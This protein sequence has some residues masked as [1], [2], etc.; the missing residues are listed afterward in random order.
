MQPG[1]NVFGFGALHIGQGP[2]ALGLLIHLVLDSFHYDRV[3]TAR[4]GV[5]K[6][7][8][9]GHEPRENAGHE[10]SPDVDPSIGEIETR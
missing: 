7:V 2:A 3:W 5:L 10:S 6:Q 4:F 1:Y 9:S 8:L